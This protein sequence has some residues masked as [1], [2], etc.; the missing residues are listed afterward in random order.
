M[1]KM[2]TENG[3]LFLKREILSMFLKSA[4]FD[5]SQR[6][7]WSDFTMVQK[8]K[9]STDTI[10]NFPILIL[11]TLVMYRKLL[12]VFDRAADEVSSYM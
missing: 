3:N 1:S 12:I 5:K 2:K 6:S 11:D 10:L 9:L 7:C 8:Q 4:T